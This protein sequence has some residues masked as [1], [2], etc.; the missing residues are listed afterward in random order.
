MGRYDELAAGPA[1]EAI[2]AALSD[3]AW[4]HAQLDV[5][6]ALAV[7]AGRV[8]LVTDAQ[9]DS[10]TEAIG[11]L[12]GGIDLAQLAKDSA[13]GANPV[14]PLAARLK[15]IATDNA[16]VHYGA[17]SQ[18]IIDTANCLILTRAGEPL[19]HLIDDTLATLTQ[20]AGKH[21]ATPVA[22]RTLGQQ[23]EPTT[24]GVIVAGWW[25]GIARAR[26]VFQESLAALPVQYAGAA[27]NLRV[28]GPKGLELHAAI[29]HELG[30]AS[31]PVV[32]HTDRQPLV[33]VATAAARLAGALR[34]VAGDIIVHSATEIGEL[35]EAQ[36][37]GSSSMPH[38]ANPAA[39]IACV[40][41]A[42][43]TPALAATMLDSLDSQSQ[44]AVGAWHAEWQTIRDLVTL[45]A[46]AA[47]RLF[48][49]VDGIVVD[50]N[51]MARNLRLSGHDAE[52][53][54]VGQADAIFEAIFNT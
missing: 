5:E 29:A 3:E 41:Y 13:A 40:G 21:R 10:A 34:K 46:S 2:H 30:L 14:I 28:A 24:F 50:H 26:D 1:A 18:D 33:A 36:P 11:S 4:V 54:D 48:A 49:S 17:T 6:E 37:G 20:L 23:A 7:A 32:W 15:E 12:R 35:R 9:V 22:A 45:T 43:R 47:A 31:T 8:G 19:G 51:A 16:A 25:Q 53:A 42:R 44:R 38:K 52:T 27:G 39:A